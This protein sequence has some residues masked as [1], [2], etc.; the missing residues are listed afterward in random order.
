MWRNTLNGGD[1][2]IDAYLA[3]YSARETLI[4]FNFRK[5]MTVNPALAEG[6]VTDIKNA[7]FQR[8]T[9]IRRLNGHD[10]YRH[11]IDGLK[12]GVDNLGSSMNTFIGNKVLIELIGMGKVGIY[13]EMPV[14]NGLSLADTAKAK[15][16][17]YIYKREE[18]INWEYDNEGK[19]IYVVLQKQV[20]KREEG[21][22]AELIMWK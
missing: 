18:I 12:G 21:V 17:L 6:A 22:V 14:L 7:I 5:T 16:Y 10:S 19:L 15:P 3:Q 9:E 1:Q 11:A 20:V 4:D 13:I 2:Y 8:F